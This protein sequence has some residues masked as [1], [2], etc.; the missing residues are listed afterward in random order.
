MTFG[1]TDEQISEVLGDADA[2]KLEGG[3][4]YGADRVFLASVAMADS[5]D[6]SA[7]TAKARLWTEDLRSYEEP[8]GPPVAVPIKLEGFPWLALCRSGRVTAG[9]ELTLCTRHGPVLKR[10]VDVHGEWCDFALVRLANI[11]GH[12]IVDKEVR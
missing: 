4:A 7:R 2:Y 11:P 6:T 9:D 8:M 5:G 1:W 12:S 3:D 10:V